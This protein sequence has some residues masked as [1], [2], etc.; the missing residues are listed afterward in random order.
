MLFRSLRDLDGVRDTCAIEVALVIHKDL[1]LINQ[2]AESVRVDD[3]IAIALKL[4]AEF[5]LRLRVATA[6]RLLLVSGVWRE[7]VAA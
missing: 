3:A 5:W 6:A 7:I 4:T 1:G 2:P